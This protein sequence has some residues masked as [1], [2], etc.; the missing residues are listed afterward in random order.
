[1]N[2]IVKTK[3]KNILH[4]VT[5]F[6]V[7]LIILIPVTAV[8]VFAAYNSFRFTVYQT[9][10][11]SSASAYSTFTYRLRP[12]E[13][14]N[15]MPAGSNS[16]GYTFTLTGNSSI[17]IGPLN[18]SQRGVYRYELFQ[19]IGT[20]NPGYIY[21]SQIYTIE[22][23]VD[24]SLNVKIIVLNK[25][26]AKEEYIKFENRYNLLPTNP[27]L[28]FDIPVRKTVF[29]LPSYNSI[30]TF[31]LQAQNISNS[32]P[33]GSI[34]GIK[35]IQITGSGSESFGVWSYDKAG[36]YYYTV[37]E[38]N[39]G[40]RGYSYDTEVYTI[41][42]MVKEMDGELILSRIVTNGNN[43]QVM[44]LTFINNYNGVINPPPVTNPPPPPPPYTSPPAATSVVN[45]T[46]KVVTQP[47]TDGNPSTS[48]NKNIMTNIP[49]SADMI[50][51][52]YPAGSGN[53]PENGTNITDITNVTDLTGDNI[54]PVSEK[55][56]SSNSN[57]GDTKT[58]GIY[59]P[60]TGDDANTNFY[61]VLLILSGATAIGAAAYL[62]YS[63]NIRKAKKDKKGEES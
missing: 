4:T 19:V 52:T 60:K 6:A 31:R 26:G 37:Y 22:V 20:R 7:I 39:S 62:I 48:D 30:F 57:G 49:T 53:V 27:D 2:R 43:K 46:E 23:H 47:P 54:P 29:G 25:N 1:M 38:V 5:T 45:T 21:D 10:T 15:P 24:M 28:M 9:F 40:E 16:D 18:C 34:N 14:G 41:T 58:P 35:N 11:T 59:G 50:Y 8:T 44:S 51:P 32:M 36:T 42:D 61:I 17:E 63:I 13:T 33:S 12:L 3:V 55:S 56:S